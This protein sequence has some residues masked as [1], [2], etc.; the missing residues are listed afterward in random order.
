MKLN[1]NEQT[2][3]LDTEFKTC[4]NYNEEKELTTSFPQL[5][6]LFKRDVLEKYTKAENNIYFKIASN[7]EENIHKAIK[8]GIWTSTELSN[9]KLTNAFNNCKG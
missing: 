3:S 8:Y 7:C 2:S 9:T 5:A 1:L 4:V 6:K